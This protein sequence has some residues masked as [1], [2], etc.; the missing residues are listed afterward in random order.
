MVRTD[1]AT[2]AVAATNKK[3]SKRSSPKKIPS[4]QSEYSPSP[5]GQDENYYD[6]CTNRMKENIQKKHSSE[7]EVKKQQQQHGSFPSTTMPTRA[8]SL[9]HQHYPQKVIANEAAAARGNNCVNN[10]RDSNVQGDAN[11][12][13]SDDEP[14]KDQEN[15]VPSPFLEDNEN[16]NEGTQHGTVFDMEP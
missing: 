3:I 8:S 16:C 12:S 15:M 1:D 2:A 13:T 11:L 10:H 14:E 4:C 9:E 6:T 5:G 7:Q